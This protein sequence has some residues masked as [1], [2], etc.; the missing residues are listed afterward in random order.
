MTEILEYDWLRA[1]KG[2]QEESLLILILYIKDY[3]ILDKSIFV[4]VQ[5]QEYCAIKPGAT[6]P[7]QYSR[8]E[9]AH[10]NDDIKIA[11]ATM[12]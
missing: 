12:N 3:F 7:A 1:E 8:A 2:P 4:N 5:A 9:K 11:T 6:N 10:N